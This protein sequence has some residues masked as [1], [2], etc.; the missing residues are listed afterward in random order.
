[1]KTMEKVIV[2]ADYFG[3]AIQSAC[4][5]DVSADKMSKLLNYDL[6]KLHRYESGAELIPKDILRRVFTYAAKMHSV[7]G[8][9]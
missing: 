1:M 6:K 5:H 9:G 7:I 8:N 2:S 3:A 4:Q